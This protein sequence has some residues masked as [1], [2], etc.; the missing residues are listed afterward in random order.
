MWDRCGASHVC[1][2]AGCHPAEFRHFRDQHGRGDR[3]Y[4]ASHASVWAEQYDRP[5]ADLFD[6][7][8]VVAAMVA[9]TI[10]QQLEIEIS[11]RSKCQYPA[12]LKIYDLI[13]RGVA[14][15]C[16]YAAQH[17]T[18]D[19]LLRTGIGR[20]PKLKRGAGLARHFE[21]CGL[22]NRL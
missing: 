12:S 17:G 22:R 1:G 14:L 15:N 13:L 16:L 11:S 10:S 18:S 21:V 6:V 7:Q 9:A 19:R 8:E 2:L 4:A 3:A 5:I 20:R